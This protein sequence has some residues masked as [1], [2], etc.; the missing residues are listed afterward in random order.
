MK[1]TLKG[2]L[3]VIISVCGVCFTSGVAEGA[4][5]PEQLREIRSIPSTF[6]KLPLERP[7]TQKEIEFFEEVKTKIQYSRNGR[8]LLK[9]AEHMGYQFDG[10]TGSAIK[11]FTECKKRYINLRE[12]LSID[13]AVASFAFELSNVINSSRLNHISECARAGKVN[14]YEYAKEIL[15][16]EAE[17][18][19]WESVVAKDLK[20][21]FWLT[22]HS[23]I[24][25]D[26]HLIRR[27]YRVIKKTGKAS[28]TGQSAM[29]YYMNQ[30]DT[31]HKQGNKS[32]S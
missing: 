6:V 18:I 4:I 9:T 8:K 24:P 3:T 32:I 5:T 25:T 7:L 15:K 10:F 12:D 22:I 19:Y 29:E 14:R 17:A 20:I 27:I 28:G 1:S 2:I 30:Y 16:V 23:T 13:D 11:A 26:D 21:K 31:V